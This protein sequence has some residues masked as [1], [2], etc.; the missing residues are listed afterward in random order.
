MNT[1]KYEKIATAGELPESGVTVDTSLGEMKWEHQ[2]GWVKDG[3]IWNEAP[4]EF[5][6]REIQETAPAV[7]EVRFPET[8]A[9]VK[10]YE[11]TGELP[12]DNQK[13]SATAEN[14]MIEA[15]QKQSDKILLLEAKVQKQ[16]YEIIRLKSLTQ[17]PAPKGMN[18][19]ECKNKVADL[20]GF[21]DWDILT[22]K[23]K[24]NDVRMEVYQQF[25]DQ[26]M[27]LYAQQSPNVP[28]GETI[29]EKLDKDL[30]RYQFYQVLEE[31]EKYGY[32][33]TATAK[34]CNDLHEKLCLQS[35]ISNK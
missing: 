8:V 2:Y 7:E 28:Q 6:Y 30:P 25:I 5:W 3:V 1:K 16:S 19:N 31:S 27:Q 22:N 32:N 17:S 29:I 4:P 20:R 34:F 24:N 33:K 14:G 11:R 23:L 9:E 18:I 12:K 15:N 26:A 13:Q 35:N 21:Y 10:K